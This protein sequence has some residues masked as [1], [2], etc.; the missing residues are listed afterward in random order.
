MT[1]EPEFVVQADWE[2]YLE[3]RFPGYLLPSSEKAAASLRAARQFLR[4]LRPN[5]PDE[6]SLV[7]SASLMTDADK[8]ADLQAL[9]DG[10]PALLRRLPST[11]IVERREWSG[12]CQG[13]LNI[14]ETLAARGRGERLTY[15]TSARRR[16]F[17][18]PEAE[19]LAVT[20]GRLRKRLKLLQSRDASRL[21][22]DKL[23][24][25]T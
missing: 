12:G 5:V 10:L 4:H 20:L 19:L 6:L 15:I 21:L 17:A 25:A 24:Y 14:S 18:M 22:S 16:S 9:V 8:R 23:D 11:A 2:P 7:C 13:R 1:E 3:S